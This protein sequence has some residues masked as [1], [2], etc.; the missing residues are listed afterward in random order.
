MISG[1]M[2]IGKPNLNNSISGSQN[3]QFSED[4]KGAN[5]EN[6]V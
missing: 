4:N 2:K 5:D 6:V 1:S 3:K